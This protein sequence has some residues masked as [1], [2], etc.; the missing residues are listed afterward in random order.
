MRKYSHEE[1]WAAQSRGDYQ[2][3]WAAAERHVASTVIG[4]LKRGDV[5]GEKDDLIGEGNLAAGLAVRKWNPLEAALSTHV[6]LHVYRAVMRYVM[7][8]GRHSVQV[9]DGVSVEDLPDQEAKSAAE[10]ADTACVR[11]LLTGLSHAERKLISR[12]F[13]IG[14][15][16][17][18]STELAVAHD[19]P[20]RTMRR[21]IRAILDKLAVA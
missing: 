20:S 4:M 8:Q 5:E 2:L 3:L 18:T 21:T 14:Q 7:K 13:G 19:V 1:L 17:M 10:M 6:S 15:E 16:E 12:Y 11:E 9:V